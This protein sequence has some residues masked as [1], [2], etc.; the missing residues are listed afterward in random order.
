MA[1]SDHI[2]PEIALMRMPPGPRTRPLERGDGR[3]LGTAFGG[4]AGR[5]ARYDRPQQWMRLGCTR[6]LAPGIRPGCR[7]A[8]GLATLPGGPGPVRTSAAGV[9]VRRK[10][11][12]RATGAYPGAAL[13]VSMPGSSGSGGTGRRAWLRAMSGQPGGG[14]S[15]L[16]RTNT[17]CGPARIEAPVCV[18][19]HAG[20]AMTPGK[21]I[22]QTNQPGP[23]KAAGQAYP[24][25]PVTARS[26]KPAPAYG[27]APSS[28]L[29][30]RR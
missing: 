5:R 30:Q 9:P 23:A 2:H 12:R 18:Q 29:N 3:A 4:G 21:G 16:C 22:G 17:L 11:R 13:P 25:G 6:G 8:L 24:P 27:P 19:T 28:R 14:S 15:P 10:G 7:C 20:R 26:P 1:F